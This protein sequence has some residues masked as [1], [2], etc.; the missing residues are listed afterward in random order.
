MAIKNL[1]DIKRFQSDYTDEAYW[2]LGLFYLKMQNTPSAIRNFQD[3]I[4]VTD[5]DKLKKNA[6]KILENIM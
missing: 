5:N 2:Y 6:I 4:E 1:E 3:Y